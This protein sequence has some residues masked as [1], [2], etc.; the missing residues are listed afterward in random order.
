VKCNKNKTITG[1]TNFYWNGVTC[2]TLSKIIKD[3]IK[4]DKYWSGVKHIYSPNI[5]SKFELCNMI[6]KIYE[7]NI[8]IGEVEINESKYMTLSTI[9]RGC[10]TSSSV[11]IAQQTDRRSS[12]RTTSMDDLGF[13]M[14]LRGSEKPSDDVWSRDRMP[15]TTNSEGSY[16]TE[17]VWIQPY[18]SN[19]I[20]ESIEKQIKELHDCSSKYINVGTMENFGRPDKY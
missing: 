11:D 1:Y 14:P 9:D 17:E 16:A 20:I 12:A 6:N 7:L 4:N 3:I 13:S 18:N 10:I 15:S 19:Y 8:N 2:L 5:V